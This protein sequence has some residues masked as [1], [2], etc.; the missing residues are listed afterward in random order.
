[1]KDE[2][3]SIPDGQEVI[4]YSIVRS[5]RS[6]RMR[7]AVY[8]NG[9]V[10]VR[11]PPQAPRAMVDRFVT[12]NAPWISRSVGRMRSQPTRLIVIDDG[13]L[14]PLF[15]M[16]YR[17][18]LDSRRGSGGEIR[19][20]TIHFHADEVS[21]R[22]GRQVLFE[23]YEKQLERYLLRRIS[24]KEELTG[25]SA[26]S[27][28]IREYRS[29]WGSCSAQGVVSFNLKLAAF[30]ADVIDYVIVHE[31]CHLKTREHSKGFWRLVSRYVDDV[32]SAR[33]SLKR[34]ARYNDFG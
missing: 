10:V 1:M 24:E 30:P 19:G 15:G 23:F 3:G 11:C 14:V 7:I 28:R 6:R 4:E 13:A 12:D 22:S 34:E 25:L 27:Y 29:K 20:S 32:G 26:R 31:L 21:R 8:P 9:D 2:K 33:A 17:V 18:Q 16:D 5:R